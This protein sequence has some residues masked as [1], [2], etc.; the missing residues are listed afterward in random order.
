MAFINILGK[1]VYYQ[2]NG[3]FLVDR[4][5]VLFIHG[6]GGTGDIWIH[7]LSGIK[8]YNLIAL[9]LP[10]H[11]RSEGFA[12]DNIIAYQEFVW[13]FIQALQLETLVIAGHSMG[14]AIVMDLALSHP[15]ALDGLI[16]VNSAARLPVNP[17]M[18]ESMSRGEHPLAII[19]YSYSLRANPELLERATAEMKAVPVE[20][21]LADFTACAGF[22]LV[23]R[24][25]MIK[26]PVLILSGQD[27]QMTPLKFSE[28]L[29]KEL[30]QSAM[31]VISDAGHMSMLEQPERVNKAIQSFLD[32]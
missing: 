8:G 29:S 28:F 23:D 1:K 30:P 17:K 6:A 26:L 31:V 2:Q 16:F 7:Q 32:R 5:T 27:D 15:E 11:G 24:V 25:K 10:G 9:D 3:E 13:L 14:G 19:K 20:V 22:N 18:L 21:Y 4:K 12:S